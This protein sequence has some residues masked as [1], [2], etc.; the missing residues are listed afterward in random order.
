MTY[1]F[2]RIVI[3]VDERE[4]GRDALALS[5]R[6]VAP[7]GTLIF[8]HVHVGDPLGRYTRATADRDRAVR[9][10]RAAAAAVGVD[11]DV[12]VVESTTPGRGLHELA[13][14]VDADLLVVG[15]TRRS[16][17]GRVLIGDDTNAALNG[18]VCAVAVAP[19]GYI[20]APPGIGEIGVGYDG[21]PE[22]ENALS[23][24]RELAAEFGAT[25]S[26]CEAIELPRDP[27]TGGTAA[28]DTHTIDALI[29][30]ARQRIADLGGVEAH[31]AYGFPAEELGL[32]SA[33]VDLLVV[34]SRGYGPIGRLM[35]GS[36]SRHL[37]HTARS[38][39]LVLPRTGP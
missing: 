29:E 27:F 3:G 33:S 38:P 36:T 31:A 16:L 1:M 15:S 20:D 6:L 17:L 25:L 5:A 13:E 39:L 28:V 34:G 22:S 32:Y 12:R 4:G 24:A 26:A 8:C 14:E 21:S 2:R 7:E 19:A 18:A 23:V 11:G 35:H 9:D 37:A 30:E 10:L